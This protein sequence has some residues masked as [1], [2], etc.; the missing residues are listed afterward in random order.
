MSVIRN[1][2]FLIFTVERNE[3][4]D[5]ANLGPVMLPGKRRTPSLDAFLSYAE[6]PMRRFHDYQ[7]SALGTM[8]AD[9]IEGHTHSFP[10]W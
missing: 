5:P 10:G 3:A 4:G 1:F 9:Q 6:V 2:P 8:D 7:S